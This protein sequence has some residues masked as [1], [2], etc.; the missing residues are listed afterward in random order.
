MNI[1]I[2]FLKLF[3][4]TVLF[5][6]FFQASSQILQP[7]KWSFSTEQISESE[8]L[9][10]FKANID[11]GWHLYAQDVPKGGPLPTVIIFDKSASFQKLGKA[12]ETPKPKVEYDATFEMNVGSWEKQATFKQKISVLNTK[13][14]VISGR[15]EYMVCN[16]GSC[17]PLEDDFSFKVKGN[18]KAT[19]VTE[20]ETPVETDT[21]SPPVNNDSLAPDTTAGI[22]NEF[23]ATEETPVKKSLFWIF[24]AGFIGGLIALLT[25]CVWPMIPMTVSFFLKRSKKRS[26]AISDAIVYGLAIIVI[27][28][29]LGL[30]V[31]LIFGADALNAL[32]TS[33]LF[34]ILFFLLLVVFAISFF[35]A[36]ELT[37]PSKWTNAMDR[38]ADTT[39]GLLSIFFM[40]F[41]LALVSF[42]C[43]GPIIGTLLV[44]AVTQGALAPTIGMTGFATALAI[45]FALFAI[46]PSWLNT[47]PKSGGW[48]N[49][50]KVTLGFL[51]LALALKFLSNADLAYHWGILD[52]EVFIV[53]WISIFALL[54][55][56][57][58]GW[59]K[60]KHDDDSRHVSVPKL[61]LAIISFSFAIYMIPGLWGAPLKAIS[62]FT[63]PIFTQDFNLN[64]NVVHAK[65]DDYDL[66][67]EYARR[68]GKPVI[69]D[70]TGW[71]CVNCREMEA[72]V[73]TDPKVA[74][75][76]LEDYVLISLYVDDKTD[77]PEQEQIEVD[78]GGKT[79]MLR[80][81][82]NKWSHHQAS[83]FGTNSQPYYVLLDNQGKLLAKPRAYDKDVQ[84]YIEWLEA[85]LK[86]Y[87]SRKGK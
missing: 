42:S 24:I 50:V 4:L 61:F 32:S 85:G 19:A 80:T 6:M 44:E 73:W 69:V 48:M 23:V 20:S 62:A 40:A 84:K 56:Y 13:D 1:K 34:N 5:G 68:T 31:T 87:Q 49:A 82:G 81:I 14:F 29:A 51:E 25:P 60:L 18:P 58:M 16:E 65:F 12:S 67:M 46:F 54:G 52:R 21:A 59:Y 47:M 22:A 37:L 70:Y 55:I 66:G 9:L 53:L 74:K 33:A 3:L 71:G 7:V 15:I 11:A 30:G 57:Y 35:G 64:D 83:N 79:R 43:T 72:A 2:V 8:A 27:Y 38:K 10:V 77:L 86:E 45:P 63:P 17:I 78:F 36:F 41:T 26:K 28:V 76:L 39:S 75:L